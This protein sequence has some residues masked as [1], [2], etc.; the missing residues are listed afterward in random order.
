MKRLGIL[1]LVIV[2]VVAIVLIVRGQGKK[3]D[4]PQESPQAVAEVIDTNHVKDSIAAQERAQA[5]LDSMVMSQL[6]DSLAYINKEIKANPEDPRAWVKLNLLYKNPKF[7]LDDTSK[8]YEALMKSIIFMHQQPKRGAEAYS[9]WTDAYLPEE[10]KSKELTA[11]NEAIRKS[12]KK[13]DLYEQRADLYLSMN[14]SELA[15]IDLLQM[16]YIAP[17]NKRGYQALQEKMG[18]DQASSLWNSILTLAPKSPKAY[19]LASEYLRMSGSQDEALQLAMKGMTLYGDDDEH[20]LFNQLKYLIDRNADGEEGSLISQLK[21]QINKHPNRPE[22]ALLIASQYDGECHSNCQQAIHYYQAAL[23]GINRSSSLYLSTIEQLARC[24]VEVGNFSFAL[25]YQDIAIK[26]DPTF[27]GYHYNKA[28]MLHASGDSKA[29]IKELNKYLSHSN[30]DKSDARAYYKRASYKYEVKDFFG[31]LID[32]GQGMEMET[33]PTPFAY[34]IRGNIYAAQG[35][36]EEANADFKAV[37]GNT[38]S[39]DCSTRPFAYIGLGQKEEAMKILANKVSDYQKEERTDE[40]K[41]YSLL[42]ALVEQ[43]DADLALYFKQL[44]EEWPYPYPCLDENI[45]VVQNNPKY[46]ELQ[47]RG[48]KTK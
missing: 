18:H 45:R 26:Q 28:M 38:S 4:T 25:K 5:K 9:M 31:A 14:Q 20:N 8:R 48:I 27:A 43:G 35:K 30:S 2:S 46:K 37:L 32:V 11:L 41:F 22:W 23:K 34:L 15:E 1:L 36:K 7:R 24:Y 10:K 39:D 16:V 3:A 17:N 42:R 12:S 19:Y 33:Q 21:R 47:K 40:S 29:A 44:S 13:L 6:N